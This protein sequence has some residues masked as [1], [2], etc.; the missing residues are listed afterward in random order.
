MIR[1][2]RPAI[3]V[4]ILTMATLPVAAQ[5]AITTVAAT[6]DKYRSQ[7]EKTALQQMLGT[8]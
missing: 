8:C 4:A 6:V 2:W 7:A 5:D 1:G 3:A